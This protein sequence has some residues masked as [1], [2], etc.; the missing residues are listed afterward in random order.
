MN[1]KVYQIILLVFAFI[2]V[3]LLGGLIVLKIKDKPLKK[4]TTTVKQAE[5][6]YIEE[7]DLEE[8]VKPYKNIEF[9][10]KTVIEDIKLYGF[11][12]LEINKIAVENGRLKY[13]TDDKTYTANNLYN[14][15]YVEYASDNKTY[16]ELLVYTLYGTYYFNTNGNS[17]IVDEDAYKLHFKDTNEKTFY[18]LDG[19][20]LNFTF[21]KVDASITGIASLKDNDKTYFVVKTYSDT[22]LLNYKKTTKY[23]LDAIT[24]VSLGTKLKDYVELGEIGKDKKLTINYDLSLKSNDVLKYEDEILYLNKVYLS[25]DSFYFV[26]D[27][28]YVLK[29]TDFDSNKI[30]KYNTKEIEKVSLDEEKT[31]Q[32]EVITSINQYIKILYKDGST[33]EIH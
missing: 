31:Y 9:N 7:Y 18:T 12:K 2:V 20:I 30:T 19:S 25:K 6:N 16:S 15:K 8:L 26:N 13:Y 32:G 11:D 29:L 21:N 22:Y 5:N 17:S 3:F 10:S 24:S 14:V 27:N 23:G 1:K 28:I 33:E 4:E